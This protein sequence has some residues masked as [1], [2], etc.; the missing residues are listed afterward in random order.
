MNC[1]LFSE[2]KRQCLD[3]VMLKSESVVT[4]SLCFLIICCKSATFLLVPPPFLPP[5]GTCPLHLLCVG[6]CVA[7]EGKIRELICLTT[8]SNKR[9][10]ELLFQL[11]GLTCC[12]VVWMVLLAR[13]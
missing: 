7:M 6:A 2:R 13:G 3:H 5:L 10:N 9:R 1:I 8:Y 4:C 11:P 12:A